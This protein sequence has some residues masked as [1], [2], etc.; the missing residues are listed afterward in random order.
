MSSSPPHAASSTLA[1]AA[2]TPV[3]RNSAPKKRTQPQAH[4]SKHKRRAARVTVEPDETTQV[5]GLKDRYKLP[6][7]DADAYYVPDFVDP[8][9]A[10]HWH[11]EL[12]KLE[13]CELSPACLPLALF[14]AV[15]SGC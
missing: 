15:Q 3:P 10:Q 2:S 7:A 4:N 5:T 11:D 12:L 9:T 1:T 13:E 14:G 6:L 8:L